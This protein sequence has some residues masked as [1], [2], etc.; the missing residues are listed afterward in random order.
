[1]NRVNTD[2]VIFAHAD[3]VVL[4]AGMAG[5]CA[6][7]RAAQSGARV[8]VLDR[9]PVIGGSAALSHGNV[10]TAGDSRQLAEEDPGHF[11]VH[12][13]RVVAEFAAVANWLAGFGGAL[14]PRKASSRRQW[15]RFDMPL[16]F[17]RLAQLVTSAGGQIHAC[18]Q[19]GEVDRD[20][21]SFRV[22]FEQG[23]GLDVDGGGA[24]PEGSR[25][26]LARS[27]VIAT[28]GRQ[29]DPAVR[30]E[31]S[32]GLPAILRGNPYSNGGGIAA[33]VALGADVNYANR[34]FYG[35]L[36]PAGVTPLS[37]LD[38]LALTLYHSTHGVLLDSAG[39]RFTDESLGD[40]RNATALAARGGRG[41]L[42]WSEKVQAA[43]AEDPT[44]VDLT[45]DRWQY[46]RD[47]GARVAR[48]ESVSA[49]AGAI[50]S[51]GFPE[52][53]GDRVALQAPL[54][55][56]PVFLAEVRPGITFTYGGLRAN[57]RGQV[58]DACMSPIAGLFVAGADMSDIY[59]K[60]YCGGLSAAAVTGV[61]AGEEAAAA[62]SVQTAEP[63][64][65]RWRQRR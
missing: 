17:L 50:S 43:A 24:A 61:Q 27:L 32:G 62:G 54:D 34:G 25:A 16:T 55:H 8:I 26:V 4:G 18:A 33:A 49:I 59:H 22:T 12:S 19:V 10:W 5:M 40:A 47:R 35:H 41:I 39:E 6:A 37:P 23:G 3:V 15:Q 20:A 60:G 38:F 44:P 2:A 36:L 58:L 28:G 14:E 11:R 13:D 51:W 45:I 65:S 7:A 29:A 63:S 1:M 53:P 21:G 46:A 48:A 30:A 52:L 64:P 57:E 42:L 9:A 56:G 31:L